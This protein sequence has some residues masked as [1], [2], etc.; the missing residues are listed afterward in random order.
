MPFKIFPKSFLGI[1]IGTSAI[2]GVELSSFGAKTSLTNY[3]ILPTFLFY[4][5]EIEESKKSIIFLPSEELAEAIKTATQA[6]KI[7]AKNCVFS[8]PDFL[9][10]FTTINL[11]PMKREEIGPAVKIE[12]RKYIPVPIKEV[13]LDWQIVENPHLEKGWNILLVAIPNELIYKYQKIALLA[14]LKI[15]GLEAEIFSLIR[16]LI[17]NED[18][19]KT[20]AILDIGVKSTTC[21]IIERGILKAYHSLNISTF[22]LSEKLSQELE[23][24]LNLAEKLKKIWG[25]SIEGLPLEAKEKEIYQSIF[26]LGLNPLLNEIDRILRNFYLKEGKEVDKIILTGGSGKIPGLLQFLEKHFKKEVGLGN[27]FSKISYPPQLEGTLRKIGPLLSVATG[28]AL[29][30]LI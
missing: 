1:D 6:A 11:P 24:D 21:T 22:S 18:K 30:S 7:K 3:F 2:K 29:R 20:V 27:P 16:S 10:F 13:T 15:L 4:Q 14:N 17:Q 28:A 26:S 19:E 25:F 23:I 5:K 12:A 9:T 8:L